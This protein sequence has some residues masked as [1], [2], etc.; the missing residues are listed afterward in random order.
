MK[1]VCLLT[2]LIVVA[3]FSTSAL[4]RVNAECALAVIVS[5]VQEFGDAINHSTDAR[6]TH[7][8]VNVEVNNITDLY[9]L[10]IQIGWDTAWV[11]YVDH[12]KMIPVESHPGGVLHS[13]TIPV[14]DSVDETASMPGSAPGTM[15]WLAEASMYPAVAFDG[16]GIAASFEFEIVNQPVAPQSDVTT[17]ISFTSVTLA[18]HTGNPISCTTSNSTLVI[19][20][21]NSDIVAPTTSAYYDGLWHAS[22]FR[23][24]LTAVDVGSGVAE[25]YYRING[26]RIQ[27]LTADGQPYITAEG[28]NNTL[29]Y[30]SV[31]HADN[32]ELP[33]KFL[34]G[35]K[36]D[37]TAPIGSI[38]INNDAPY[39]NSVT[40]TLDL[41]ASDTI[42][43]VD[44]V[45][46]SWDGVWDTETWESFSLTKSWLLAGG[47][48]DKIVY[49]QIRDNAGL[50]ST[51]LDTIVLDTAQPVTN[52]DYDGLW[53]TAYF[54]ISLTATDAGS[55]VAQTYYRINGGPVQSISS[56]GQPYISIEGANNTLEYWSTDNAGNQESPHKVLTGIR[57]DKT[58]PVIDN[59]SR[60]PAGDVQPNRPV[61]VSVNIM[62]MISHIQNATMQYSINNGNTWQPLPMNSNASDGLYEATIPGQT[63]GTWV[64]FRII[65]YD[66]AGNNAT[67]DGAGVYCTYDVVPEYPLIMAL[68]SFM[69]IILFCAVVSRRKPS[70]YFKKQERT[71]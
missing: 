20:Y 67:V 16:S 14:M 36:L 63:A 57:L 40:V 31:D 39:T 9:G 56:N 18:D 48:G 59:P 32:E 43:G 50:V 29:E 6:G 42:S 44:Q 33:H 41:Q 15:Y 10:D 19:H 70:F 2:I 66:F 61:K 35:I 25:T 7:F 22:D 37:K 4:P 55:G 13:P 68:A 53:R 17:Y 52:D 45:R 47:S 58:N 38:T 64:R 24:N 49:Y 71:C 27:N 65:A 23:I 46:Y 69:G 51:Y 3:S 60:D 26:G 28:S 30:W 5:S 1:L 12:T 8:N 34:S 62:D 11:R 21:V 54:S